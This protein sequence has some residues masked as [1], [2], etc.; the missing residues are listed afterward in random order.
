MK[1]KL[2]TGLLL[3]TLVV[4]MTACNSEGTNSKSSIDWSQIEYTEVLA[5]VTQEDVDK[6]IQDLIDSGYRALDTDRTIATENDIVTVDYTVISDGVEYANCKGERY[7]LLMK[8]MYLA[9]FINAIVG[10]EIGQEKEIEIMHPKESGHELAGKSATY[11]ITLVSLSEAARYEKDDELAKACGLTTYDELVTNITE[12]L[13]SQ[14]EADAKQDSTY[15][16]LNAYASAMN[17]VVDEATVQTRY[18]E[19]VSMYKEFATTYGFTYEEYVEMMYGSN[20]IE[21]FED[22]IMDSAI[23]DVTVDKV[24]ADIVEKESI[25]LTEENYNKGLEEI[26]VE[27]GSDTE[28]IKQSLSEEDIKETILENLAI[29]KLMSSATKK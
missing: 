22:Y 20:D 19:M 25:E 8:D 12:A 27:Y 24:T 5:E 15:N 9:E 17:I 4:S 3:G 6:A 28:T 13:K 16:A 21:S 18:E 11:K 26:A 2:I 7:N 29:D 14:K 23:Y 10:M 1:K